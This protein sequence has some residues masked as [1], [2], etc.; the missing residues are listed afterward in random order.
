MRTG[1]VRS[2]LVEWF[3]DSSSCCCLS[4]TGSH[5]SSHRQNISDHHFL[6]EAAAARSRCCCSKQTCSSWRVRAG[7]SYSQSLTPALQHRTFIWCTAAACSDLQRTSIC[8]QMCWNI[9]ATP[10][11]THYRSYIDIDNQQK[12]ICFYQSSIQMRLFLYGTLALAVQGSN[13]SACLAALCNVWAQ[14]ES[15]G[16]E[17]AENREL[18]SVR[19]SAERNTNCALR[20]V[21]WAATRVSSAGNQ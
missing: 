12:S 9:G 19:G 2:C 10:Q 18:Y 5:S 7:L 1:K 17:A 3:D 14:Q 15:A 13:V 4:H 6:Q 8:K 11:P 16:K 20:S 21:Q